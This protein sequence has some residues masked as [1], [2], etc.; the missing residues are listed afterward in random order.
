MRLAV[1]GNDIAGLSLAL[2]LRIKGHDV[3]VHETG[4]HTPI[5]EQFTVIAPFRDLFLKSGG[6]LDDHIGLRE[7]IEPLIVSSSGT[8]IALPAAGTQVPVIS[9]ALGTA[10]GQQWSRLLSDAAD[11][12]QAVRTGR[13][14]PRSS[15]HTYLRQHI[16]DTRLHDIV[17]A[18]IPREHPKQ[19]SDATIIAPYLRQTFGVWQFDGG[20]AAFE[21]VLRDRCIGLGITVS[22]EPCP[23]DALRVDDYF[24]PM[25][26]A[27]QR[28]LRRPSLTQPVTQRLGL[29]FIGM[30]AEAIANRIGRATAQ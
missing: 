6:A 16:K 2:R 14:T 10:A 24:T 25:F 27:P 8:T 21:S 23:A 15:L 18:L 7:V 17:Y 12:W 22:T 5:A 3:V 4:H 30:A 9:R 19:L 29:P 26:T 11:T 1:A 20:L 28:F 13:F